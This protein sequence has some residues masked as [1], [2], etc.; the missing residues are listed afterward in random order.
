MEVI[1]MTFLMIGTFIWMVIT[2]K[3]Y[4]RKLV[5]EKTIS[6]DELHEMGYI[7]CF[8]MKIFGK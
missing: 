3:N 5:D 8:L 6:N 2:G 1:I 7:G 4:G